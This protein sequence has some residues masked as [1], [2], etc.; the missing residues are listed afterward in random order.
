MTGWIC[1]ALALSLGALGLPTVVRAPSLPLFLPASAPP[2]LLLHG[3]RDDLVWVQQSRR[4]AKRLGE[5][6]AD[7]RFVERPWATH[8]FDFNMSGP[9]GQIAGACL[10]AFLRK[11]CG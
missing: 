10:D 2:F 7:A 6:G 5:L 3:T 11:V 8:A 4:F 9:G 1:L